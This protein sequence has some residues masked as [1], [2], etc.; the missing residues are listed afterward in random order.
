M[1]I[2]STPYG[3]LLVL[4][5]Y[6]VLFLFFGL[7]SGQFFPDEIDAVALGIELSFA[8]RAPREALKFCSCKRYVYP[9]FSTLSR[10]GIHI[11]LAPVGLD[12]LRHYGKPQACSLAGLFCCIERV[13]MVSVSMPHPLSLNLR[14]ASSPDILVDTSSV[15]PFSLM[16]S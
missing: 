9:E 11:Y 10:L 5:L 15:P 7:Y 1:R 4:I 16:A 2:F 14:T 13:D 6:R 12:Y 8:S 3:L